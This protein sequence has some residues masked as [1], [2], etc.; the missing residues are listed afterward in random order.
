MSGV[1]HLAWRPTGPMVLTRILEW[2]G[3]TTTLTVFWRKQPRRE[4]RGRIR[5]VGARDPARLA[6][7]ATPPVVAIAQP[8]DGA[9]LTGTV[10]LRASVARR[11]VEV[12]RVEYRLTGEGL[13]DETVAIAERAGRGQRE[14]VAPWDAGSV[15]P[16]SYTLHGV[17]VD[18]SG[19][20]GRSPATI[21]TVHAGGRWPRRRGR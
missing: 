12:E 21:V 17:A 1:H 4:H 15:A 9:V 11:V 18:A 5:I 16:G 6:G 20:E 7:L 14:W 19:T 2:L 3:F 10:E 13:D 8:T